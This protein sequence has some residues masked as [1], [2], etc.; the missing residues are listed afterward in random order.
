MTKLAQVLAET[1]RHTPA[2]TAQRRWIR[3]FSNP[4]RVA[5]G[6]PPLQD[7]DDDEIPELEFFE[8][9]RERGMLPRR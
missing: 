8:R 4:R 7:D 3:E 5:L 6:L 2:T 9:A 1:E